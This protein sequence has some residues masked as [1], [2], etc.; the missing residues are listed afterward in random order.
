[1]A[2]D[3]TTRPERPLTGRRIGVT[4]ARKVEEQSTLLE[5][6]GAEVVRGPV[7][8]V[9]AG[10]VGE[11]ELRETTERVLAAPVDVVVATTGIGVRGWFAAAA[12]WGL[13][14]RL[15]AHLGAAEVLARGPKSAGALRQHGLRERWSPPSEALVDVLAHLGERDLSGTRVVLQEHGEALDGAAA[16]LRAQGAEVVPVAVYRVVPTPDTDAAVALLDRLVAGDLDAVTFTSAM[17]VDA[18]MRLADDLGVVDDV[19]RALRE[20]TLAACVGAVTASA[21]EAWAVPTVHPERMRL[22]AMVDR[23]EDALTQGAR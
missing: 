5:R 20:H 8:A 7:L 19:V 1:M 4:A 11:T 10:A 6:R 14:E 22:V 18:T 23:L 15:V 17:A 16:T 13:R 2:P 12:R 3:V 9:D 21:F